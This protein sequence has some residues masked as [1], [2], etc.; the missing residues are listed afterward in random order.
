MVA[1]IPQ[2][3]REGRGRRSWVTQGEQME[4]C[5]KIKGLLRRVKECKREV[6]KKEQELKTNRRPWKGWGGDDFRDKMGWREELKEEVVESRARQ[7]SANGKRNRKADIV[8]PV[9]GKYLLT[10]K[11]NQFPV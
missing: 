7:E 3:E 5:G 8:C 9:I 6:R 10:G 11:K 4:E 2:K 1:H